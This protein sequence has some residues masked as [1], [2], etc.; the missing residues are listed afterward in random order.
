MTRGGKT[1]SVKPFPISIAF[2]E[3]DAMA[4]S[5][6]TLR[7]MAVWRRELGIGNEFVGIGIDRI[8]Y[9]KGIVERL[10]ALD[11]FL[12]EYPRYQERLTFV[13]VGVNLS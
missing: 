4:R 7:E 5:H 8:D 11:R 10:R 1:T 6:A 2:D 9:T 13:Q 12:E 3:H